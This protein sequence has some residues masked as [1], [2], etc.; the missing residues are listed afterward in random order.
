MLHFLK[1]YKKYTNNSSLPPFPK[2][3]E[4]DLELGMKDNEETEEKE[5]KEEKEDEKPNFIYKIYKWI[6]RL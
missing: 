5:E 6:Y 2:E 1:K 4:K 3:Y